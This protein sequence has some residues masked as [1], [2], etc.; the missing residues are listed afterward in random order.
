M[1]MADDAAATIDLDDDHDDEEWSRGPGDSAA[2]H[3]ALR[4]RLGVPVGAMV[5]SLAASAPLPVAPLAR[6]ATI[7]VA[8]QASV[9]MHGDDLYVLDNAGGAN[10]LRAF[11]LAGGRLLWTAPAAETASDA[12]LSVIAGGS[13]AG[14]AVLVSLDAEQSAGVHTEVFDPATGRLRW[15][16]DDGVFA[17]TTGGDVVTRSGAQFP[18]P[19]TGDGPSAPAGWTFQRRD[20]R[21]GVIRW[22]RGVGIDCTP[23]LVRDPD[24]GMPDGIVT[25]CGDAPQVRMIDIGTGAVAA[26][27]TL[28]PGEVPQSFVFG[29]AVVV[30]STDRSGIRLDGFRGAGL[31]PLWSTPDGVQTWQHAVGCGAVLCL[32]SDFGVVQIDPRTGVA[33]QGPPI[34]DDGSLPSIVMLPDR[35]PVGATYN[36]P[37]TIPDGQAA[38]VPVPV[39]G[40]AWIERVRTHPDETEPLQKLPGV[41]VASCLRMDAYLACATS[42]GRI[43]FWR[44]P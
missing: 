12:S 15:H 22:S 8:D 39:A 31:A 36:R 43:A 35:A 6:V 30:M 1:S 41:G 5:I 3:R 7:G 33:T 38:Y 42:I 37:Q 19:G 4:W 2:W 40:D 26:A 14:S 17:I 18:I 24:H 25:T 28:A 10:R 21:T 29:G 23:Q 13:D 27:R 11:A 20:L 16:S 34:G 32:I 9:A 44:L